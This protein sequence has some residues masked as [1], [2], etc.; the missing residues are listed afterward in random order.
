VPALPAEVLLRI[1]QH[2]PCLPGCKV[3]SIL[4]QALV[5]PSLFSRKITSGGGGHKGGGATI[6]QCG[7]SGLH[8]SPVVTSG[9]RNCLLHQRHTHLV[10]L[11]YSCELLW[12]P[13]LLRQLRLACSVTA[14]LRF[15]GA[16]SLAW[17]SNCWLC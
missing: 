2:C 17:Y 4:L 13:L 15:L 5:L 16:C 3:R 11:H 12:L 8:L 7:A 9:A 6:R 14:V 1:T 10:A